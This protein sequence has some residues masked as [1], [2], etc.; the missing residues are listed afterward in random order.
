MLS[1]TIFWFSDMSPGS[2]EDSD[3]RSYLQSHADHVTRH[4]AVRPVM[5]HLLKKGIITVTKAQDVIA[6]ETE[7]GKQEAAFRL[8]LSLDR[9][10]MEDLYY[11]LDRNNASETAN[12]LAASLYP[13][14]DGI[15]Q[16]SQR[17]INNNAIEI[18]DSPESKPE[19]KQQQQQP[20]VKQ[21]DQSKSSP[22]LPTPVQTCDPI[23]TPV[24]SNTEITKKMPV[25]EQHVKVQPVPKQD[26]SPKPVP[27]NSSVRKESEPVLSKEKDSKLNLP[28]NSTDLPGA[29]TEVKK[30]PHRTI[31]DTD[32]TQS[33]QDLTLTDDLAK[34]LDVASP[35]EKV[36]WKDGRY[37]GTD[38]VKLHIQK[39]FTRK[40]VHTRKEGDIDVQ[41][42]RIKETEV[43]EE[44]IKGIDTKEITV[45]KETTEDKWEELKTK[46]LEP[47]KAA[48]S[49]KTVKPITSAVSMMEIRKQESP[50]KDPPKAI[51]LENV[52]AKGR[53]S[54]EG[55]PFKIVT[56][57]VTKK[58]TPQI[59]GH[60]KTTKP[61]QP[62]RKS[63]PELMAPPVDKK[64][65][66]KPRPLSSYTLRD[67]PSGNRSGYRSRSSFSST[68]SEKGI[69]EEPAQEL[70]EKSQKPHENNKDVRTNVPPLQK[71]SPKPEELKK[72]E[73]P[74]EYFEI[75]ESSVK[76][77]QTKIG[78]GVSKDSLLTDTKSNS[79]I[80]EDIVPNNKEN[81]N[82]L[83]YRTQYKSVTPA[84]ELPTIINSDQTYKLRDQYSSRRAS[85]DSQGDEPVY[86]K[87]LEA[88][89]KMKVNQAGREPTRHMLNDQPVPESRPWDTMEPSQKRMLFSERP[90]VPSTENTQQFTG[91]NRFANER[92]RFTP[93]DRYEAETRRVLAETQRHQYE[94][95]VY[96]E[97]F[98]QRQM[99]SDFLPDNIESP[100]RANQGNHLERRIS[101]QGKRRNEVDE[102][103]E[104]RTDMGEMPRPVLKKYMSE[105]SLPKS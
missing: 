94:R 15:K 102:T 98:N 47:G 89:K 65:L 68:D 14:H 30:R 101:E 53:M 48:E 50:E 42:T 38:Y 26:Q 62:N 80:G 105:K 73:K 10:Q 46:T 87:D 60:I 41:E 32:D 20:V 56:E 92:E 4:L 88:D 8:I 24:L 45:R 35:P 21:V 79:S 16:H 69:P 74:D 97:P 17:N 33:I 95:P 66:S 76:C 43:K 1:K 70:L 75:I 67:Q 44:R 103:P 28:Q 64:V 71:I 96:E 86:R 93:D 18:K 61:E 99:T 77:F 25:K 54:N 52:A 22:A 27:Q 78:K 91:K 3:M 49:E 36:R 9:K 39:F 63:M 51:S 31:K 57:R 85:E 82:T 72:K 55:K 40:V 6:M 83:N 11:Y 7:E 23:S 84:R 12:I 81:K 29:V 2:S 5:R 34:K 58:I 19:Q 13:R 104:T 90:H 100:R 59:L 37:I